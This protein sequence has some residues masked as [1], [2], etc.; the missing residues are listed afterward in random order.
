ML[1]AAIAAT[2]VKHDHT[3]ETE[4]ILDEIIDRLKGIERRLGELES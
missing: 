1:T 4:P 2:F 3:R